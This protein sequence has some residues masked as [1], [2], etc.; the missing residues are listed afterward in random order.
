MLSTVQE[1][2]SSGTIP[3]VDNE[4]GNNSSDETTW[5]SHRLEQE[6]ASWRATQ[7]SNFTKGLQCQRALS[8]LSGWEA[9]PTARDEETACTLTL[10]RTF[11]LKVKIILDPSSF[12][13][14]FSNINLR[15]YIFL[16]ALSHFCL[17]QAELVIQ[18]CFL[19]HTH[20]VLPC[21][22]F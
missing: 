15:E 8:S 16:L 11:S 10:K 5:E 13:F 12:M 17:A 19:T 4:A 18:C 6:E 3:Q 20:H 2:P 22:S 14:T 7:K 21:S 1:G 9:K